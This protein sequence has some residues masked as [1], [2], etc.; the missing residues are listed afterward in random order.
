MSQPQHALIDLHDYLA[1]EDA[2]PMRHEY[3]GGNVYA[4]TGGSMRHNR[5]ALNLASALMR[6][7]AGSP[8]QVFINDMKLHVQAA[9][10]ASSSVYYPDVLVYCGSGTAGSAKVV[11]S[12]ALIVEVLSDSTEQI[13]RREK[14]VAYQGLAGLRA[15]WIVSQNEQQVEVH[16]RDEHGRWC[17]RLYQRGDALD[18]A[19]LTP[20]PLALSE[21]YTGTDLA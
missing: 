19:E 18:T 16:Q 13:D 7:L 17:M 6:E 2:S 8:C 3:L 11:T 21:V 12:A 4:M 1:F 15:Y 14:R 20:L 5:I 9:D 10:S